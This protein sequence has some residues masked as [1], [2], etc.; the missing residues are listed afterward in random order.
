MEGWSIWSQ[1]LDTVQQWREVHREY[2]GLDS[3]LKP[4]GVSDEEWERNLRYEANAETLLKMIMSLSV[5]GG[6]P[7][8]KRLS[9]PMTRNRLKELRPFLKLHADISLIR[10]RISLDLADHFGEQAVDADK[11]ALRL[12]GL[13]MAGGL[14]GSAAGFL[15]RAV[16]LYLWGFEPETA[17]MCRAVLEAA[18]VERLG[19]DGPQPSLE[20]L[21]ETAGATGVLEGYHEDQRKRRGWRADRGSALWRADRIRVSGNFAAHDSPMFRQEAGDLRNAFEVVRDLTLVLQDLFPLPTFP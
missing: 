8:G 11:R 1:L 14:S 16:S 15:K 9:L 10:D 12:L 20:K 5:E 17:I 3:K 6:M 7:A 21:L 19:I 4:E 2:W 13:L 18:L